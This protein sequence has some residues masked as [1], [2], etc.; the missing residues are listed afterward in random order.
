MEGGYLTKRRDIW[1]EGKMVKYAQQSKIELIS[2]NSLEVIET[3][4][5]LVGGEKVSGSTHPYHY[6]W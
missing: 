3:F 5:K 2:L 4:N 6:L 1:K